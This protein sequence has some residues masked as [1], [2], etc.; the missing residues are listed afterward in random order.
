MRQTR[1]QEILDQLRAWIDAERPSVLPRSPMAEA[2]TYAL[3]QWAAL[4]VYTTYGFLSIDNKIH[5]TPLDDL[6]K[7]LPDVWKRDDNAEP[8]PQAWST[9]RNAVPSGSRNGHNLG[10]GVPL[11]LP[12]RRDHAFC[13]TTVA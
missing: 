6:S 12:V 2:I 13:Q 7:F 11:A 10:V 1:S 4:V 8:P 9:S 3:N 5:Q